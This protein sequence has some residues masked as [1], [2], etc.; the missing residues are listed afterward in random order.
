MGLSMMRRLEGGDATS[1]SWLK[2]CEERVID[3]EAREDIDALGR[4][5]K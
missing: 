5:E 1:L 4:E 3:A 2:S